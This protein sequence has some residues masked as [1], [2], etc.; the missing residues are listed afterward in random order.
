MNYDKKTVFGVGIYDAKNESMSRAAKE[1]RYM[2]QRC[3]YEKN[4]RCDNYKDCSVCDE[5]HRYSVFKEW[6]DENYIEGWCLDKDILIK[7]NKVYSPETCC[8]VPNEINV[9]FTKRESLRGKYPIGVSKVNRS[10]SL[11]QAHISVGK[12]RVYLGCSN[13]TNEAFLL[14]K[15]GKEQHIKQ[16]ANK[17]KDK[18]EPRVYKALYNYK[19]EITD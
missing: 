11:Y 4:N 13:T 14:Y 16:I 10:E 15:E 8:F 2:L 3:Y 7:G 18:L 1:W 6:F 12:K 9:L 5:W 19:V 17:W